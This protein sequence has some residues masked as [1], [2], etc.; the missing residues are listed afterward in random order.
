MSSSPQVVIQGTAD[1]KS[2]IRTNQHYIA[3]ELDAEYRVTFVESLGLRRPEVTARDAKRVYRRLRE[4]RPSFNAGSPSE[5]VGSSGILVRQPRTVPFH[6]SKVIRTINQWLYPKDLKQPQSPQVLW[7]F[8][9]V[10]YADKSA[11]HAIVYHCVD[12]YS[13]IPRI[14]P[15]LIE[16]SEAALSHSANVAIASSPVVAS[17]L[18]AVGFEKILLWENVADTDTFRSSIQPDRERSCVFAGNL[19]ALKVDFALLELL[20]QA[21]VKLHLAGPLSEGGG[22]DVAHVRKLVRMGAIHHGS[23]P[24]RELAQ[25][26][27]RVKIGL[28][29]YLLNPYTRGV[30]PLKQYEY[31]AAGLTVVSSHI[32]GVKP[33]LDHIFIEDRHEHFVTRVQEELTRE[34]PQSTIERRGLIAEEHSWTRRGIEARRLVANL[35][36]EAETN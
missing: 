24:P 3:Q 13:S 20:I 2:Q 10:V 9:P 16:S 17:H 18:E 5:N 34:V 22:N 4:I 30:S 23:L 27:G 36:N 11:Y 28:I 15:K 33:L 12:L 29:P 14:N 26:Y 21:G 31:L 25:L 8:S 1:W 19:S 7:T 6:Q 35:L 32:P